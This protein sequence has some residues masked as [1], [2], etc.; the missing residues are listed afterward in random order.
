MY[1]CI[2]MQL[3]I[4][5]ST[6]IDKAFLGSEPLSRLVFVENTNPEEAGKWDW[7]TFYLTISLCRPV[8][9]SPVA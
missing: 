6:T 3:L 5:S 1:L 7:N 8:F 9:R 2:S 4:D